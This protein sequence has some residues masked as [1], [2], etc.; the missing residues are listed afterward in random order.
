MGRKREWI[1]ET[2]KQ[3]GTNFPLLCALGVRLKATPELVREGVR[4]AV[5]SGVGWHHPRPLRRSVISHFAG[6]ARGTRGCRHSSMISMKRWLMALTFFGTSLAGAAEI[7]PEAEKL[8]AETA[9]LGKESWRPMLRYVA[10]LHVRSTHPALA[11]FAFPWEEIGP[12]YVPAFGHWDLIHQVLDVLPVATQHAHE[13]LL[14]DVRL[15][16]TDGF[17]PGSVWMPGSY[18]AK[19]H[20]NQPWFNTSSQSHPP[21]WVVA[22]EDYL[23]LTGDKT[24]CGNFSSARRDRS[25][26]S[27]R[28][29]RRKAA[30]F[31]TRT[32][33][34]TCGR[35]GS[36]KASASMRR[37]APSSRAS[38]RL[39]TCFNYASS[40]RAGRNG[41]A[42]I[43]GRGATE[44]I[45]CGNLSDLTCGRRMTASFT[46]SGRRATG[47]CAR[48]RSK[49]SGR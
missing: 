14:N 35:A 9:T 33:H 34:C 19:R 44:R 27:R 31:T 25:A 39:A 38:M 42:R 8:R 22:A 26:G 15:Q 7:F 6:G 47:A 21:V 5:E 3:L 16:L 23:T 1:D 18:H 46:T 30:G 13:Q 10:D 24:S 17:L 43:R 2:R 49:A 28:T 11:P 4:I 12:G 29:A 36:T 20:D 48:R 37:R 32:F 40:P 41:W 45:V